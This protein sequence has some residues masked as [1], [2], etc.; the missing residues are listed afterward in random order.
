MNYGIY[1]KRAGS[2]DEA[3]DYFHRALEAGTA[4]VAG[5]SAMLLGYD[6][7]KRGDD[8]R[9][10]DYFTRAEALGDLRAAKTIELMDQAAQGQ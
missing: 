10:R 2:V 7:L 1:L 6:A 5:Q 8:A 3:R 4:N 9:A